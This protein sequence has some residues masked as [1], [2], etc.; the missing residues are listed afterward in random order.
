M[1]FYTCFISVSQKYKTK[2]FLIFLTS[3]GSM[4]NPP[5][6]TTWNATGMDGSEVQER[7]TYSGG[8]NNGHSATFNFSN[9]IWSTQFYFISKIVKQFLDSIAFFSYAKD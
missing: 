7:I 8:L 5:F 2:M 1:V 9:N 4:H 3:K 6:K